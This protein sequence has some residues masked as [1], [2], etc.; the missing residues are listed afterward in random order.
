MFSY[1]L[2]AATIKGIIETAQNSILEPLVIVVML[3][4]TVVFIW[5]VIKFISAAGD[6]KKAA[7]GKQFIIWG[8]FGLFV[9]VAMWGLVKVIQNTFGLTETT[10]PKAGDIP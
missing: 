3:L 1:F 9:I 8:L 4:A 5:G 7:E 2:L 10:I 6:P